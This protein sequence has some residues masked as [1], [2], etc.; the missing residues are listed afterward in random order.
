MSNII[1]P[2]IQIEIAKTNRAFCSKCSFMR[3]DSYGTRIQK[4]EIKMVLI[5]G[6]GKFT[7]TESVCIRCAK[8]YVM[9]NLEKFE[10]IKKEI[11][12]EPE[13]DTSTFCD[14]DIPF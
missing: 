1:E 13:L 11:F 9:A 4:D 10:A 5:Q 2:E 12:K 8:T 14:D 3:N 6:W 7:K